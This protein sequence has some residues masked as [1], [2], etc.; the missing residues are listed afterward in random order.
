MTTVGVVLVHS[1]R[2]SR[3]MWRA[4]L[5]TLKAAG[6]PTL[7]ID[8]PGHGTRIGEPFTLD[9]AYATIDAAV[10][11]L[12]GRAVVVGMSLGGYLS[13]GYTSRHPEKV[14]SLVAAG[15]S[16]TTRSTLRTGWLRLARRIEASGDSG[17]RLNSFMVRST[18][19]AAGAQ[20]VAAGGFALGVMTD[21]LTAMG[22]LDP[23]EALRAVRCPVRIVN[24]RFDHFRSQ[25][26]AFLAAARASGQPAWLVVV[27]RAM[28][29]VSLDAPVAFSRVVL[30]AVDEVGVRLAGGRPV[31][32]A[33]ARGSGLEEAPG[34]RPSDERG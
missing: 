5:E 7:A 9:E 6:I 13:I 32:P 15:C 26:R 30:E 10:D 31:R 28:H 3:T 25:E 4:Q 16:T 1:V 17:E 33:S 18:L 8:L 24:G 21:A 11:A 34:A 29:L 12:G 27:P 23:I 14:L 20:D 19:S 2:T 22:D